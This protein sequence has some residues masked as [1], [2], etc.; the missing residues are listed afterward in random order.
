[1]CMSSFIYIVN[2]NFIEANQMDGATFDCGFESLLY[3][4]S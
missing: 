3:L 4:D 1:M 2:C